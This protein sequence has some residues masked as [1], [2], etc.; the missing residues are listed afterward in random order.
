MLFVVK[1]R[2]SK[3][4]SRGLD[5]TRAEDE[6]LRESPA[7][8]RDVIRRRTHRP[9]SDFAGILSLSAA[10][11][12][13]KTIDQ[14]RKEREPFER[15]RLEELAEAFN[16][17]DDDVVPKT[18]RRKARSTQSRGPSESSSKHMKRST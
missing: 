1:P 13:R 12:M 4:M 3:K 11:E 15:K 10:E 6:T 9:L 2:T 14:A 17:L 18:T 7:R 8:P 5:K 16:R